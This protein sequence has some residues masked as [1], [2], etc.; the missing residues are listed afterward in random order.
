MVGAGVVVVAAARGIGKCV[1]G[2]IY[3]LKLLGASRAFGGVGRD[4]VG[5][6]FQGLSAPMM[7]S[8][9]QG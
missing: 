2:V 3:F 8:I 6:G 5:M 4:A 7:V 9:Q 1:V